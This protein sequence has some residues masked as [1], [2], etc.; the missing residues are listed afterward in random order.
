MKWSIPLLLA[1]CSVSPTTPVAQR[2]DPMDGAA[3]KSLMAP[4]NTFLGRARIVYGPTA[5]RNQNPGEGTPMPVLETP[6]PCVG[7]EAVVS[8]TSSPTRPFDDRPA[9][10]LCS[11][12]T[13]GPLDLTPAGFSGCHML[14]PADPKRF[15]VLTPQPGTRFTQQNGRLQLTWTPAPWAYGLKVYMQL[16]TFT[17]GANDANWLWSPAVELWVGNRLDP[18]AIPE[19]G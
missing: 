6:F 11:F 16:V 12:Q 18:Q 4:G 9:M 8:W 10:L 19:I 3:L 17:P 7:V 14:V 5:C 1:A 2:A 15:W 13:D